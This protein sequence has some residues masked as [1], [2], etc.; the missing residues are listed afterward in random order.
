[1]VIGGSWWF[2]M[3]HAGCHCGGSRWFSVFLGGYRRILVVLDGSWWLLIVVV[4]GVSRRFSVVLGG[5]R[6]LSE[7]LGGSRW[8]SVGFP[9][10]ITTRPRT[11]PPGFALR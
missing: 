4:L 6:W 2:L 3:G 9:G 1:M 5:S 7:D 10:L 8:F 11:L